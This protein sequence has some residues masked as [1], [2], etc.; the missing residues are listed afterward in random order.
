MKQTHAM[1]VPAL[2][3]LAFVPVTSLAGQWGLGVGVAVQQ[4]PQQGIDTEAFVLPFP[5]YE[6]E[7]LS[8]SLGS[9]SYSLT[10]S[11]RF[12]FA[13]EGQ[14]RFDG[15]DPDDSAMLTG[16]QERD[17]TFDAGFSV[18]TSGDWGIATLQVVGDVLSRHKGYE[19]SASYEYPVKLGRWIVAPSIGANWRSD[20]LVDYYYGVRS[21]EATAERPAY[22]GESVVN[23]SVGVTLMREI[24]DR[25]Q[26][27]GGAEY[28]LLGDDIEDSPII[29]KDRETVAFG[30][31]VYLF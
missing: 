7:R 30:A 4:Q 26:L 24:A 29:D 14:V 19:I 27:V 10:D 16:M 28:V 21:F 13:L 5:S 23:A 8:L 6:G 18:A 17:A 15:Y 9:V 22:T 31:I 3:G 25:W 2:L 1:V 20:D 11:D 12:R